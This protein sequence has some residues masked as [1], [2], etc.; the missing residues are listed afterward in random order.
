MMLKFI[1]IIIYLLICII[2]INYNQKNILNKKNIGIPKLIWSYWEGS[3]MPKL[4]KECIHS[5]K[6]QNPK[7]KLVVLNDLKVKEL[8]NFDLETIKNKELIPRKADFARLLAIE[9]YGGIWIDSSILTL[10]PFE[11]FLPLDENIDFIGYIA[12][13]TTN[14][15]IPIIENWFF[16]AP[17]N[18]PLIQ[19]WLNESL[20][21]NEFNSEQDYINQVQNTIDIQNLKPAL[22]YLVMHVT[23]AKCIQTK[24]YNYKL[25]EA[26][27]N[28]GPFE[29][30]VNNDW[31]TEKAIKSICNG[32]NQPM[33]KFRGVERFFIEN[34]NI[35]CNI[36]S[37]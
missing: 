4:V 28:N 34:N 30:L 1:I 12:P 18:S 35:Q 16:A 11:S 3:E 25:F 8:F 31:N 24:Y 23:L 10:K 20:F 22:P 9:K 33:I 6:K 13:H 7:Y 19:D 17:K 21:M 29:Y 36:L 26:L 5:W 27:S 14:M 32:T 15:D 2:F 37:N